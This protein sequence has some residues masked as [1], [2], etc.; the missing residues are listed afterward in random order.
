MSLTP[1]ATELLT[2]LE[3]RDIPTGMCSHRPKVEL[4]RNNY[5]VLI[6]E[7]TNTLSARGGNTFT[8]RVLHITAEGREYLTFMRKH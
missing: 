7:L 8:R 2:L 5:A 6:T 3:K 4:I 1:A